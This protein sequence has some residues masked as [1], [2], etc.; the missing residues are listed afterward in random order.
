VQTDFEVLNKL[1]EY[2]L[3]AAERYRRFVSLVMITSENDLAGLRNFL[4]AHVRNSDVMASFNHSIAVL[5]GET[6]ENGAMTAINRYK[7]FF[8]DQI[9]IRYS[10]VTYP[11][12]GGRPDNLIE[13][14]YDR[15]KKARTAMP[16]DFVEGN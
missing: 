1:L 3:Q 11:S 5:M 15:L 14:A 10:L 8:N 6:D 2:E 12:D 13:M 4:G 9:D 16:S 7:S